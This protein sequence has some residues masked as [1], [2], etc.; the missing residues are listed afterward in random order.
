MEEWFVSV[1][2][3][4]PNPVPDPVPDG[5]AVGEHNRRANVTSMAN[6]KNEVI[7]VDCGSM[8]KAETM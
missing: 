2:N 5:V 3:P 7:A 8:G 6:V 1:P 4:A